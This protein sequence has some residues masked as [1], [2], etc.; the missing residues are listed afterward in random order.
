MTEYVWGVDVATG[1][2]DFAFVGVDHDDVETETLMTNT[3]ALAGEGQRWGWLDRQVRI[4]VAQVQRRY[5]PACIF[6]ERPTGAR[7]KTP[8]ELIQA[9]GVTLA[10]LYEGLGGVPVFEMAVSSWKKAII[11]NGN[12][13]KAAGRRVGRPATSTSTARTRPTPTASRSPAAASSRS[14]GPP[15]E[16]RLRLPELP[17]AAAVIARPDPPPPRRGR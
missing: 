6:V 13:S 5:P 9:S 11:G 15:H 2:L 1:H 4:Y 16:A 14:A 10:A 12:A 3:D 7:N 17:G 8:Y